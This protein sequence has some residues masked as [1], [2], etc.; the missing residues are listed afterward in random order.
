MERPTFLSEG[1][2]ELHDIAAELSPSVPG[3]E[4]HLLKNPHVLVAVQRHDRDAERWVNAESK[5]KFL[6][7]KARQVR[8]LQRKS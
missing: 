7:I 3:I 4:E 2:I 8:V 1:A 5:D 6:W